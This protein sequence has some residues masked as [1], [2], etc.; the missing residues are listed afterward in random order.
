MKGIKESLNKNL[1]RDIHKM[2]DYFTRATS[3]DPRIRNQTIQ[4]DINN[5]RIY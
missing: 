1:K 2:S 5:T 3:A 4:E